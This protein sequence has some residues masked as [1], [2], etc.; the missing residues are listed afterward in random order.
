[1]Y[2]RVDALTNDRVIDLVQKHFQDMAQVNVRALSL[3]A[4]KKPDITFWS[5][6]EA[7][8]LLGCGALR[9][10]NNQ[11]GEVKSMRTV[12]THLRQGV[13]SRILQKIIEE[14]RQ[15]GYHRLSIE[16]GVG[17]PFTSARK[18]YHHFGFH[19]CC[20][21]PGATDDSNSIYM[22]KELSSV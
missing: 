14:A 13:A 18:L 6:W 1:M 11:H 5:A 20:T 7:D 12:S 17:G 4:L 2:I 22:T 16:T 3:E 8:E 15:R 9:E 10:I 21:F 19:E